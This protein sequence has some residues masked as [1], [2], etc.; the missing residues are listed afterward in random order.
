MK[1]IILLVLT[2]SLS[3]INSGAPQ[4]RTVVIDFDKTADGKPVDVSRTGKLV[5]NEY[6]EAFGVTLTDKTPGTKVVI[7]DLRRAYEGQGIT[8]ASGHNALA[9]IGSNDPVSFTM[10]FKVTLQTVKF[11]RPSLIAG[12]TGITFPEWKVTALDSK[13]QQLG[14][15]VGESVGGYYSDNPAKTFILKGPGIKAVRFDSDNHRFAA[16]NAAII[17]DLTLIE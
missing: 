13:G 3:M 10:T 14:D 17:D 5:A 6:L 15:P 16:F 7:E 11:T 2:F 4:K 12:P 9:H 8:A 1:Q